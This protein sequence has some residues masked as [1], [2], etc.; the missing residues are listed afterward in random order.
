MFTVHG[1]TQ[2]MSNTGN[3]YPD[4]VGTMAESFFVTFK[5]GHV[6]WERF[7]TTE[8]ARRRIFE[9]LEVFYNRV[10]RQS[11]LGYKSP[12]A[13]EQQHTMLA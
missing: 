4:E 9:Y 2:S 8:E 5:K 6:F 12:V 10:R 13:F 11:A 1:I 3:C 7:R